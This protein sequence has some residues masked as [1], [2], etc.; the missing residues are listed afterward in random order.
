MRELELSF[1]LLPPPFASV[2]Q[3]SAD[4][5]RVAGTAVAA[6]GELLTAAKVVL[7]VVESTAAPMFTTW[8]CHG[9]WMNCGRFPLASL[10]R[11]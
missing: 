4:S 2:K 3:P 5:V 10:R 9:C 6:A 1:Q 8:S 7:W 11:K